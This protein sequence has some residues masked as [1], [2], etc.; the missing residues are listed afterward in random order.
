[1]TDRQKTIGRAALILTTIIWGSSFVVMKDTLLHV[2]TLYLLAIRFSGAAIILL[3]LG[4]RELKKLDRGYVGG[5]ILMGV[6]LLA[7]YVLQTYGLMF[8][9]P[10]KNAFLTSIYCVIVPFL[11]WI[12]VKKKPDRYNLAA[13]IMCIIGIGFISLNDDLKI[14]IGDALTMACGF[15]FALHIIVTAGVVGRRSPVLL[16]MIQFAT[17]AVLSWIFALFFEVF[18]ASIS[19]GTIW[20]LVYLSVMCT[21]LCLFLQIFGQKYTP[22]AQAAVI[23]TLEAVFGAATSVL[24][25]GEDL[26][27]K[28]SLGFLFTFT[29][30]IVSETKLV[31]LKKKNKI[32][33]LPEVDTK[34]A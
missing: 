2:P 14:G 13:A 9:T 22:P 20:S 26:T 6:F 30:I 33:G 25:F 10:G 27:L 7:A 21:A 18:P 16:A 17:A 12:F 28:L 4:V 32:P 23:M 34:K 24:F 15:F 8:T 31:F 19:M 29:A 11:Y 5:G 3:L 1:M